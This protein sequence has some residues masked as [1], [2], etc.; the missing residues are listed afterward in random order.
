MIGHNFDGD[1]SV[2]RNISLGGKLTSQGGAEFKGNVN[3]AGWLDAKNIKTTNKGLFASEEELI[4]C[5]PEPLNGWFALVSD[6]SDVTKAFIFRASDGAWRI[7][8]NKA[9]VFEFIVDSVNMFPLRSEVKDIIEHFHKIEWGDTDNVNDFLTAGVYNIAG[10]HS[11]GNDN[12]PISVG[13]N[14]TFN[15]TL[16]VLDST[17]N[18]LGGIDGGACITQILSISDRV[19]GEGNVY[20]RT[21]RGYIKTVNAIAW[22]SW[23]VMQTT[24]NVG[25]IKDEQ[26]ND[27]SGW[28][29]GKGMNSLGKAGFY[30]GFYFDKDESFFLLVIDSKQ[31]P[32]FGP[33][34]LNFVT[35]F[36]YGLPINGGD[37]TLKIRRGAPKLDDLDML[38]E[39]EFDWGEWKDF[40]G[41]STPTITWQGQNLNDYTDAGVYNIQGKRV[42][43]DNMPILNE[44]VIS[45]RLTVL[46]TDD[47]AGN[48]VVTQVLTLNNNSGGESNVYIRSAQKGSWKPW[49]KLQTNV[50]VGWIDSYD[51]LIDNGMYSGVY[52]GPESSGLVGDM[53]ILITLNNYAVAE[54]P[55]LRCVSQFIYSLSLNSN[56]SLRKR[57][58]R[59]LNVVWDDW[60]PIASGGSAA[61]EAQTPLAQKNGKLSLNIGD[62]LKVEDEKLV[63]D[64][65]VREGAVVEYDEENKRLEFKGLSDT[66]TAINSAK[67]LALRELFIAAGAEYNDGA[68]KVRETPWAAYADAPGYKAVHNIDELNYT[69]ADLH[70]I[71][72]DG[73]TYKYVIDKGVYKVIGRGLNREI[74]HDDRYCVHRAG[75]YYLNGLGDIT[76]EQMLAIFNHGNT[77]AIKYF[78]NTYKCR[79]NRMLTSIPTTTDLDGYYYARDCESEVVTLDKGEYSTVNIKISDNVFGNMFKLAH[80]LGR[81][82]FESAVSNG[83]YNCKLLKTV[84]IHQLKYNISLSD[85]PL[86]SKNSILYAINNSTA[87][88]AITITLHANAYTRLANDTGIVAALANKPLVTLVSA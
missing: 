58:G 83:F 39:G 79:T 53:F 69:E 71:V 23:S 6:T 17:I 55:E 11:R 67:S 21:G 20:I 56:V 52:Y 27:G 74:V 70:S 85:C 19:G 32:N 28:V 61:I 50:E 72:Q 76:E 33:T 16:A 60:K 15:A 66:S 88:T 49:G 13:D 14:A 18:V 44:G 77:L 31:A 47:G 7:L 78:L 37:A 22:D 38:I 46:S 42:N 41:D 68:D 81:F 59:G 12:L 57:V 10:I 63:L 54:T 34:S 64:D 2:G 3:I 40:G 1:V 62:G 5:Y 82:R 30:R 86:I 9:N 36:K 43:G 51:S 24:T 26:H 73:V 4:K 25:L 48:T 65:F 80:L 29:D 84:K 45:A 75:C 35:Q 8:K 87:T